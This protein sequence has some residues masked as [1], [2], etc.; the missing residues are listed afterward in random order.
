MKGLGS[1]H[2]SSKLLESQELLYMATL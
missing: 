2:E 1:V